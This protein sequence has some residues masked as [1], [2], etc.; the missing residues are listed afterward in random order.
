MSSKLKNHSRSLNVIST[1]IVAVSLVLPLITRANPNSKQASHE[2]TL[3][4][5]PDWVVFR[6]SSDLDPARAGMGNFLESKL[7]HGEKDILSPLIS[8]K[9]LKYSPNTK[10]VLDYSPCD[11][12]QFKA[13]E[14]SNSDYSSKKY[15]NQKFIKYISQCGQKIQTGPTDIFTNFFRLM[16]V[17]WSPLNHPWLK[18]ATFELPR[19]TKVKAWLGFKDKKKRPLI[20]FRPGIF[21]SLDQ[22]GAE[23]AFLIQLYE[24][25]SFNIIILEGHSSPDFIDKSPQLVFAGLDEGID[26]YLI[27][28]FLADPKNNFSNL[29]DSQHLIA[30]SL[31]A[32]GAAWTYVLQSVNNDKLNNLARLQSTLLLCPPLDLQATLDFHLQNSIRSRFL[33]SWASKRLA[34]LIKKDS[35]LLI[36][37]NKNQFLQKVLEKVQAEYHGPIELDQSIQ[38]PANLEKNISQ[39][40]P[41]QDSLYP[42]FLEAFEK[43]KKNLNS[44]Q[45]MIW[46]SESDPLVPYELNTGRFKNE[47][48]SSLKPIWSMPESYHCAMSPAYD[49]STTASM[50]Q[51]FVLS[52]SENFHLENASIV[53]EMSEDALFEIQKN[54]FYPRIRVNVIQGENVAHIFLKFPSLFESVA[55]VWWPSSLNFVWSFGSSLWQN[56]FDPEFEFVLSL[57][58]FDFPFQSKV[59][60]QVE[61][62]AI[63]RWLF[64]N[65]RTEIIKPN[66]IKFIWSRAAN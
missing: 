29:I 50:L 18:P 4:L 59:Q 45:L 64:Q 65:I 15:F 11:W 60:T 1:L 55:P 35:D 62:D 2:I 63:S 54:G 20:I 8:K 24:Q 27:S 6:Q 44:L 5:R 22:L 49:W 61:A 58:S 7:E 26:T 40:W 9:W 41:S 30:I 14:T 31:G 48:N 43:N 36:A 42:D 12:E 23:S 46:A 33:N 25:S 53:A 66:K 10:R 3:N 21:S 38:L 16:M 32:N 51:D 37:K 47:V 39:F 17:N 19:G 28:Q 13:S 57:A 56:V 34:P 52:N